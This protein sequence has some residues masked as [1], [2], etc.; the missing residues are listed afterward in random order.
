[1][2]WK[3][4][5]AAGAIM[6]FSGNI[7]AQVENVTG[8]KPVNP[9][10][11]DF[12]D[13]AVP[14]VPYGSITDGDFLAPW[15]GWKD[16]T[17]WWVLGNCAHPDSGE[18]CSLEIDLEGEF[19]IDGFIFQGDSD[20]YFL[21]YMDLGGGGWQTAWQV[22]PHP[23][24]S[25]H[26]GA[27]QTR[28]NPL[29]NGEVYVLPEPIVT[30]MLRVIPS[31]PLWAS[32]FLGT[33]NLYSVSEVQAFGEPTEPPPP[34]FVDCL[35]LTCFEVAEQWEAFLTDE[36]GFCYKVE[37]TCVD[38][39]GGGMGLNLH[40]DGRV[41]GSYG[42]FIPGEPTDCFGF[43]SHLGNNKAVHSCAFDSGENIDIE[44][45][46]ANMRRCEDEVAI[47]APPPPPPLE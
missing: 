30:N 20:T 4:V 13:G 14:G 24:G 12:F 16:G 33:D 39:V 31:P 1:M 26:F 37:L 29:D 43:F 21:Q 19:R 7:Y 3:A 28:P 10:G 18:V 9:I 44:I 8:G 17:V 34:P 47:C 2:K 25:G 15:T 42:F 40:P 36:L 45:K 6:L 46:A 22:D 32:D 5:F 41:E 38:G 23:P 11:L 35:E 27:V